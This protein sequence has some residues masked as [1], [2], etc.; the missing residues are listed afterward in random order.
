M[1]D[2]VRDVSVYVPKQRFRIL[3]SSSI[4]QKTIKLGKVYPCSAVIVFTSA[5]NS[6]SIAFI[7]P[8]KLGNAV[9]RNYAKRLL[10]A[11]FREASS[12][13]VL[14]PVNM[15]VMARANIFKNKFLHLVEELQRILYEIEAKP[16]KL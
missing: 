16:P 5:A 7:G 6:T 15:V 4:I 13:I 9:E 12:N 10:R 1:L 2:G 14:P 11:A 3:K 8:K